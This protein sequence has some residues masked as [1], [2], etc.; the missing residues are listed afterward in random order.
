MWQ[1]NIRY[2]LIYRSDALMYDIYVKTIIDSG[3]YLNNNSIGMPSGSSF[4]DFPF[5]DIIFLVIVKLLTVI[6]SDVFIVSNLAFIITFP[7]ISA[8]S[9]LVLTKMGMSGPFSIAVS[10]LYTFLPYHLMRQ[11]H[12]N[13]CYYQLV[14][15]AIYLC[16]C[17]FRSP[18]PFYKQAKGIS[19]DLGFI[20]LALLLGIQTEYYAFYTC[21]L[22][23]IAGICATFYHNKMAPFISALLLVII[24]AGSFL[25]ALLPSIIHVAN[26]GKNLNVAERT[27]HESENYALKITQMLLPT[28]NHHIKQASDFTEFYRSRSIPSSGESNMSALGLIGGGGFLSLLVVLCNRKKEYD[29]GTVL[30]QLATLNIAAVLYG[31]VGGFSALFALFVT[32]AL[33]AHARLSIF[34]AFMSLTALFLLLQ[35]F[36]IKRD[37]LYKNSYLVLVAVCLMV[38]GVWD[39]SSSANVPEYQEIRKNFDSDADF[40][41]RMEALLPEK[42]MVFQLPFCKFPEENK[43][44]QLTDYE[45]GKPYLHSSKLRWSYGAML[46]RPSGEWQKSVVAK[47]FSEFIQ[48]IKLAGFKGV[49]VDR[50]GYDDFG[51][52]LEKKLR[53]FSAKDPIISANGFN[54]FFVLENIE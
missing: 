34:I 25:V 21:F 18:G 6:S 36:L 3:W 42:S 13:L 22:L 27:V 28:K 7:L 31:T 51:K 20:V 37:N 47:P 41:K 1:F 9:T 40:A 5:T 15:V 53:T 8:T 17:L 23:L 30:G 39:Q 19:F 2:P 11:F 45:L 14:P 32:P 46:G 33:R 52:D 44:F 16:L 4:H 49:Y 35:R 43:K 12:L 54:S 48:E 24:I 50:R 29:N 38:F 26:H 10:I